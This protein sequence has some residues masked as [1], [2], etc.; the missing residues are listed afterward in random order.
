MSDPASW[1]E[2]IETVEFACAQAEL[3]IAAIK[4]AEELDAWSP[5][6]LAELRASVAAL[7]ENVLE[8]ARQR[9]TEMKRRRGET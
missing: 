9:L 7:E 8:P 3:L 6:Q 5:A 2:Q 4:R 1:G